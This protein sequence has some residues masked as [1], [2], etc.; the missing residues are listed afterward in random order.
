MPPL[1]T[2]KSWKL[3]F[4]FWRAGAWPISTNQ[5]PLS[6]YQFRHSALSF[7]KS[8]ICPWWFYMKI[9]KSENF[10]KLLVMFAQDVDFQGGKGGSRKADWDLKWRLSIDPC[11][12]W[13]F[14]CGAQGGWDSDWGG[15]SFP[16]PT[17]GIFE[18]KNI[19]WGISL[20]NYLHKSFY[21]VSK[22]N[23]LCVNFD[24]FRIP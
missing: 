12:N 24:F 17:S 9:Q 21:S 16:A 14:I 22:M 15:S 10:G 8:W 3:L 2:A 4:F 20:Q 1:L 13:H 18:G 7:Y 6:F 11:T 19:A 5:S 23:L